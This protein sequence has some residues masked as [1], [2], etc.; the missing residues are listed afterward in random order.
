MSSHGSY[1]SSNIKDDYGQGGHRPQ[2]SGAF[3]ESQPAQDGMTTQPSVGRFTEKERA[4]SM[5]VRK[6]ATPALAPASQSGMSGSGSN[7]SSGIVNLRGAPLPEG[8]MKKNTTKGK[9]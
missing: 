8:K 5:F 4:N 2:Y 9:N 6:P 1:S 7:N 3:N